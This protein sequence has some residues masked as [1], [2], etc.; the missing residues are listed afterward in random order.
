M[1]VYTDAPVPRILVAAHS[2]G[3]V[4]YERALR[5]AGAE[6]V[7]VHCP[8]VDLSYDGLL[9]TGGED[10]APSF[11][12]QD[13]CGSMPPDLVRDE[14]ELALARAYLAAGKPILGICRGCQILNVA[15]GGTM[16]QDLG[17]EGNLFHRKTEADKVHPVR[18]EEGSLLHQFYGPLFCVNSAHHQAAGIVGARLAVTARSEGGV[19]EGLELPGAPVLGVQFHPERM[20]GTLQRPDTIDGARIFRWFVDRC[21]HSI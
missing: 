4:N 9:L 3:A 11:Y 5:A 20:T 8:P 13:S 16:I 7:S 10:I 15:L 2:S 6:P 21:T 1:S 19:A 17:P 12:G 14:S 18:A